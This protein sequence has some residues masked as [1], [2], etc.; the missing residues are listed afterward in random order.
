MKFLRLTIFMAHSMHII[1]MYPNI[2]YFKTGFQ[3]VRGKE[4]SYSYFVNQL[5]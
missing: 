3:K 5:N 1:N 2:K 4:P